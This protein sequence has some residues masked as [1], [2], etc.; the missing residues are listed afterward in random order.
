[1]VPWRPSTR[2]AELGISSPSAHIL[3]WVQAV[4]GRMKAVA[5]AL[6]LLVTTV[7]VL[8]AASAHAPLGSGSNESLATATRV[9]DPTK[10]WAIYADL[11]EGGEAQYY[12][13]DM[14]RGE[15]IHVSLLTTTAAEDG[16]F[17]PGIVLMGPGLGSQ[18]FVP[19]YVETP[20]G[21]GLLAVNGTRSAQ[22][23]YEAFAPSS[24]V[25]LADVALDAPANG[26]YYVAVHDPVR[27]GHYGLAIG[28]RESFTLTEWLLTPL[29]LLSVY[30]WERQS[31]A[32]VLLPAMATAA[33]GLVL[34]VRRHR[35]GKPL[36]VAGWT[37]A[38]A[39]L[40]FLGTGATVLSQML[41]S[42]SRSSLDAFAIVTLT[43][44]IIP[45]LLGLLT[46][47]LVLRD[48]GRWS[49]RSRVYLAI[50]GGGALFAWAGLVVGPVLA[51]AAAVLPLKSAGETGAEARA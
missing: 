20:P 22:A 29:S 5:I 19:P 35:A 24:Y 15:R 38:V 18:G 51:L 44:A 42:I 34:L 49:R 33:A 11:H 9:P 3:I 39:G 2:P 25:Q 40:L 48:S 47:R 31:L 8:P 27:G 7:L 13:F 17:T 10:S 1:M 26:T 50:L 46:L 37:A 4:L 12:M 32:V 23:T 16:N 41:L 30:T 43:F 21:A 36:D 45:V 6:M 28:D 14:V